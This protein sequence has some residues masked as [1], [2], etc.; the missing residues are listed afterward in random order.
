M[1]LLELSGF[2]DIHYAKFRVPVRVDQVP[3]V[4]QGLQQGQRLKW[5]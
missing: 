2:Y 1:E 5:D 4:A 3:P